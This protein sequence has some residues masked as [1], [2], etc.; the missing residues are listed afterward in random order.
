MEPQLISARFPCTHRCT[1]AFKHVKR[2]ETDGCWQMTSAAPVSLLSMIGP[3]E[4]IPNTSL[5]LGRKYLTGNSSSI[6]LPS[7]CLTE[8][9][10]ELIPAALRFHHHTS[11]LPTLPFHVFPA[12][13]RMAAVPREL[14]AQQ[15]PPSSKPRCSK[16]P[17]QVIQAAALLRSTAKQAQLPASCTAAAALSALLSHPCATTPAAQRQQQCSK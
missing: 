3:T 2:P 5:V 14:L 15:Q 6:L 8:S 12:T 4:S 13:K 17:L 9:R 7:P 16:G 10:T 11:S 1:S